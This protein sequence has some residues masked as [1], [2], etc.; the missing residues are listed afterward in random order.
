[1]Q[2][3]PL[4]QTIKYNTNPREW[5]QDQ[6]Y[7]VHQ[8]DL[9]HRGSCLLQVTHQQLGQGSTKGHRRFRFVVF[10][11]AFLV[12]IL[13]T[14]QAQE[15][16][17]PLT[18]GL[19]IQR[20]DNPGIGI[21]TARETAIHAEIYPLEQEPELIQGFLLAL[22]LLELHQ[23]YY[24]SSRLLTRIEQVSNGQASTP[25]LL[26]ILEDT[27]PLV[28]GSISPGL[29]FMRIPEYYVSQGEFQK[30]REWLSSRIP[31]LTDTQEIHFAALILSRILILEGRF[32]QARVLLHQRFIQPLTNGVRPPFGS[33]G[34]ITAFE[35]SV[36]TANLSLQREV[37]QLMEQQ[38]PDTLDHAHIITLLS[39]PRSLSTGLN[40]TEVTTRQGRLQT[41]VPLVQ[42]FPLP[43][44]VLA[45]AQDFSLGLIEFTSLNDPAVRDSEDTPG[46]S[47]PPVQ[48]S[49]SRPA[50]TTSIQSNPVQTN[51][52]QSSS[53]LGDPAMDANSDIYDQAEQGR[54]IQV[55]SFSNQE[56]ASRFQAFVRDRGFSIIT[57]TE[58]NRIRILV[59]VPSD[60]NAI[61]TQLQLREAGIEGFSVDN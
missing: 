12:M 31:R 16:F 28:F 33:R 23:D 26:Q 47:T 24:L 50:Q 39:L 8:P 19:L 59:P 49:Q 32:D 36:E 51:P 34:L 37:L 54:F 13:F 22:F 11:L 17:R 6:R 18:S 29:L 52:A 5:S 25:A 60:S 38:Y 21:Q 61:D 41:Q 42:P 53:V 15:E 40:Q 7:P 4:I 35:L 46:S 10:P 56:N 44:Q 20:L 57:R 3:E 1:M 43:G 14:V 48:P 58:E 9:A 27:L 45:G 55:G 30:A 2:K